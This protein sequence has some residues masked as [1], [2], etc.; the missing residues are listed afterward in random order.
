MV[1]PR[2]PPRDAGDVAEVWAHTGH[3][4]GCTL[5]QT[6]LSESALQCLCQISLIT[7]VTRDWFNK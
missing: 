7:K 2:L 5:Y 1:P 3:G 4:Q 6:C